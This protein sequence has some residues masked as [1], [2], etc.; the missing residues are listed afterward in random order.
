MKRKRVTGREP[1]WRH[2][3]E[4]AAELERKLNED[5]EYIELGQEESERMLKE[6]LDKIRQEDKK[7]D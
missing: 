3:M 6:L 5:G 1:E 2:I 4:H 7:K